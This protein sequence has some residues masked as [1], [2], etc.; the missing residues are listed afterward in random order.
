M[1]ILLLI[2][3][4]SAHT[5]LRAQPGKDKL[6]ESQRMAFDK[7]YFS[8]V[9]E[10][11][12]NNLTEAETEF[13]NALKIEPTNPAAAYEL[14]RV[15]VAMGRTDEAM[16]QAEH[17]T[18]GEPANEWYARLLIELYKNT[19]RYADAAKVCE[20]SYKAGGDVFFLYELSGLQVLNGKLSK[21][22]QA[23]DRVEQQRG[24]SEQ[25]SRQ[26]EEIYLQKKDLKGAI[27]E[28]EKLSNAFPDQ[29][30]YRGLLADLYMQA[31]R[32]KEALAI[33][34]DILRKDPRSGQAAFSLADYYQRKKDMKT[35]L[36]YLVMGIRSSMDIETKTTVLSEFIPSGL[37]GEQ[38][39][40]A[41]KQ[42][43]AAFAGTHPE[44]PQPFM[45][46]GDQRLQERDLE[47]ARAEY[48]K[49]LGKDSAYS[50]AW[51]QILV[52]D[53]LLSK[54][55]W[56]RD[57]CASVLHYFP[58][59]VQAYLFRSVACRQL[60]DYGCALKSAHDGV[61]KATE[62]TMLLQML[63][64]LGDIAWYA[65]AYDLSDSAYEAVLAIDPN[66]TL[67][68]NNYAYFLSLRG[69]DLD[70]AASMSKLSVELDP[71]NSS[72]LD[73]Y[74]Y[75]LF[76]KKEYQQAKTY[77][78]KSL[79]LQPDNAEVLEHLGDVLFRMGDTASALRN[80]ERAK[81]LGGTGD[82]LDQKIRE[83]KLP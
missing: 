63:T 27:K 24:I 8:G 2:L 32:D 9:K 28:L 83:K 64:N 36:Q 31:R 72:N 4:L 1:R 16:M 6:T 39:A 61:S 70:R 19:R 79:S 42:L 62:E 53:Q 78:E 44:A 52:C 10:K 46:L 25:T 73:T 37:F 3:L 49:A 38:H 7:A 67:T 45:F 66:N 13:R 55:D 47:G 82:K 20:R 14:A 75:I 65:N 81:E 41:V 54:W 23:L 21:A 11:M 71:N 69:K 5:V 58:E 15:L 40:D 74:G 80:W 17:A 30:N 34:E 35:C 48:F 60:K 12:V 57:D 33:Y 26:K 43:I 68:L 77:I 59:Y 18:A 22:I 29:V 50:R 56:M 76:L 51:D